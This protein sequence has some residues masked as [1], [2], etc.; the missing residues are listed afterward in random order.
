VGYGGVDLLRPGPT[1]FMAQMG[2]AYRMELWWV[3]S[4]RRLS[5]SF[6]SFCSQ[7]KERAHFCWILYSAGCW[8]SSNMLGAVVRLY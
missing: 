4:M 5:N 8:V 1:L 3:F 6:I 7:L 2:R